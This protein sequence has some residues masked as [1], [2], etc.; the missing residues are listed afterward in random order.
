MENGGPAAAFGWAMTYFAASQLGDGSRFPLFGQRVISGSRLRDFI[1]M[2]VAQA[3]W[4]P[5][6]G[7]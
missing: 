6:A 4:R 7:H 5:K 3:G 2:L 1:V